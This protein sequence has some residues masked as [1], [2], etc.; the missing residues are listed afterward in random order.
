MPTDDLRSRI[1]AVLDELER[2]DAETAQRKKA[3]LEKAGI[4]PDAWER[5]T[6]KSALTKPDQYDQ[7]KGMSQANSTNAFQRP[8]GKP[9]ES[10]GPVAKHA[11]RLGITM[12]QLAEKLGVDHWNLRNWDKRKSVPE[13]I[14]KRLEA[15][16]PAEKPAKRGK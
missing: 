10:K 14:E 6:G 12:T 3:I 8:V 11:K 7:S 2:I 16:R 4:A 15:M 1:L 5:L 9:L 13:E